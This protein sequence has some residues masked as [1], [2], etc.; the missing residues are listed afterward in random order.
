MRLIDSLQGHYF[1][2]PPANVIL[3]APPRLSGQSLA[4]APL[5][6][7]PTRSLVVHSSD[8]SA[9]EYEQTAGGWRKRPI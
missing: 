6:L 3:L 5:R 9:N 4:P 8:G 7:L 1:E 2:L